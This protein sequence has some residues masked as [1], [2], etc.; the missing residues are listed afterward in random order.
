MSNHIHYLYHYFHFG[1]Y[2]HLI[3]VLITN[4]HVIDDDYMEKN[5]KLKYYINKESY[6]IDINKDSKLSSIFILLSVKS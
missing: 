1:Y 3:P 2:N 6:V 5:N 4:Y